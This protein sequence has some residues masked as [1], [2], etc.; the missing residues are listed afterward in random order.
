MAKFWRELL[1]LVGA[2]QVLNSNYHPE[3]DGQTK[4]L[5]QIAEQFRRY[6]INHQQ[7][8][9]LPYVEYAYNNAVHSLVGVLLFKVA[10]GSEG[11]LLPSLKDMDQIPEGELKH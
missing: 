9:L 7:T 8:D 11:R 6:C 5:N 2:E 3:T 4:K 1:K 10:Q